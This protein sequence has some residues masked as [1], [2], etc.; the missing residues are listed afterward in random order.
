MFESRAKILFFFI[1]IFTVSGCSSINATPTNIPAAFAAPCISA[2]DFRIDISKHAGIRDFE[3]V[4]AFLIV[5]GEEIPLNPPSGGGKWGTYHY[6]GAVPYDGEVRFRYRI[7]SRR[8]GYSSSSSS[9]RQSD[10]YYLR[11]MG[12]VSWTGTDMIDLPDTAVSD[13]YAR[14]PDRTF[15]IDKEIFPGTYTGPMSHTETLTIKNNTGNSIT[16]SQ[17]QV[18]GQSTGAPIP[19]LTIATP[20]NLTIP[21]GGSMDF[22]I[23]FAT[24]I[25]GSGGAG[26]QAFITF[27]WNDGTTN[28]A[29]GP[30][31]LH[32]SFWINPP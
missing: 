4:A 15:R 16:L 25:D 9:Y 26:A 3:S 8:S 30:I 7:R 22:D 23:T 29:F 14:R 12:D 21:D 31:W 18:L 27:D 32:A 19:G 11:P 1:G 2:P 28:C 24:N 20:I 13:V 6:T 10:R 17:P 5:N